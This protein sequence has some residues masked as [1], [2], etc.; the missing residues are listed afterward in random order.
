MNCYFVSD[1]HVDSYLPQLMPGGKRSAE[2][3]KWMDDNFLPAD[4]LCIAGDVADSGRVFVDFMMALRGRY[5]YVVYVFGNHD[6]GVFN[7]EFESSLLKIE[8]MNN[9]IAN[10]KRLGTQT[11]KIKT[12]FFKLD[13]NQ[14]ANVDGHL[15][16]GSM[17]APD[18]TYSKTFLQSSD[19]EFRKYWA[20]G[21]EKMGWKHWWSNDFFEISNDEKQRLRCAVETA[22]F[23][24]RVV[25]SHYVPLCV[26][27]PAKYAKQK[28]TGFFYWDV[29]EIIN[30]LPSGAIW[31]Y[32]HSHAAHIMEKNGIL[33]IS[34][35]IGFPNENTKL[36]GKFDKQ[37]FLITL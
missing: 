13:G 6:V 17:G 14:P 15:F 4:V 9:L 26:P 31:H 34:N 35:P 2:Y 3:H 33:F 18:W 30:K 24:P 20:K 29:D 16:V 25:V 5:K 12:K 1:I 22:D 11:H 36:L 21:L 7:N 23:N 19:R 28:T 10:F 27:A 8:A 32:G 37:E